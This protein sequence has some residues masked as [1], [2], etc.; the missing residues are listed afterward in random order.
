MEVYKS[1]FLILNYFE[2]ENYI[3]MMWLSDTESMTR[4]EYKEEF[5]SYVKSIEKYQPKGV[6]SDIL[7]AKFTIDP[8]LQEW[9]NQNVFAFSLSIGLDKAALIVNQKSFIER[10]SLEQTMEEQEGEKFKMRYF[11][12][13]EKAKQWLVEEIQSS[14]LVE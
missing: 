6:L 2:N 10:I 3:E 4:D 1:R 7:S 5:R 11:E 8:E 12:D 13:R 14:S 9:T